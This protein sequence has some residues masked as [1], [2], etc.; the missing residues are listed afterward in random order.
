[1]SHQRFC[2]IRNQVLKKAQYL[3]WKH[4]FFVRKLL[5]KK[6]TQDNRNNTVTALFCRTL[7]VHVQREHGVV[8]FEEEVE[9][10]EVTRSKQQQQNIL[11]QQQQQHMGLLVGAGVSAA[12][13]DDGLRNEV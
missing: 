7:M 3:F 13:D 4:P 9:E 8:I 2:A 10:A 11:M 5:P 6:I 1:M 12:D